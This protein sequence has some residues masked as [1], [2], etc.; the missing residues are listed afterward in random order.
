[1]LLSPQETNVL[2]D[3][4]NKHKSI[5]LTNEQ[6]NFEKLNYTKYFKGYGMIQNQDS[7]NYQQKLVKFLLTLSNHKFKKS[8]FDD[9]HK[10][11]LNTQTIF[12]DI[13]SPLQSMMFI[14]KHLSTCL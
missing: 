13:A 2:L 1:M 12:S 11:C 4:M 9:S 3:I 8:V 7:L 14:A 10:L 5:L 6:E